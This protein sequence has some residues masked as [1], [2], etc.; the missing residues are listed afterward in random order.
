MRFMGIALSSLVLGREKGSSTRIRLIYEAWLGWR[1]G[2]F[3][4]GCGAHD[5]VSDYQGTKSV[6]LP[7]KDIISQK[8]RWQRKHT[9]DQ[10]REGTAL[11]PEGF[12]KRAISFTNTSAK[13]FR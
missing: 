11:N 7:A 6:Y 12:G 9:I 1:P 4:H 3:C 13:S 5:W 10:G 2:G 8:K